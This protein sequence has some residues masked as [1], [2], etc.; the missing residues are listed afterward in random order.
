MVK[1]VYNIHIF[2]GIIMDDEASVRKSRYAG[3]KNRDIVDSQGNVIK[4]IK[5]NKTNNF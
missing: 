5:D 1:F 2:L 3:K 4:S